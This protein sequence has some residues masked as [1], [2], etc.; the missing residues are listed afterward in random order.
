MFLVNVPLS[1]LTP[2]VA[3][4]IVAIAAA[5]AVR[6]D[7]ADAASYDTEIATAL[8]RYAARDWAG[9]RAAFERAHAHK[10]G[11]RTLRGMGLSAYYGGDYV[12]AAR[13]FEQALVENRYALSPEQRAEARDLL[14]R[15]YH[16]IGQLRVRA[17][18]EG[19]AIRLDGN[20]LESGEQVLLVPGRYPLE[21]TFPGRAPRAQEIAIDAGQQ[22]SL[23]IELPPAP[24]PAPSVP[25]PAAPASA[26]ATIS[27]PRSPPPS[28]PP[29]R[30]APWVAAGATVAAGASAAVFAILAEEE[31]DAVQDRCRRAAPCDAAT[32]AE[33][34]ADSPIETYATLV[35]VSLIA[36]A[37]GALTTAALV[38]FVPSVA[39]SRERARLVAQ[40]TRSGLSLHATF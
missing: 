9:A 5:P 16:H 25:A 26:P 36:A 17:E 1:P 29:A 10:P 23:Y 7:E 22:L 31:F 32:R 37:A 39:D 28:P 4:L 21:V 11:A 13:C 24:A 6:A 35:N 2:A 38:L 12:P 19:A 30:I 18:P 15:S 20:S 34:W 27:A 33:L 3:C 40:P 14:A 8:E